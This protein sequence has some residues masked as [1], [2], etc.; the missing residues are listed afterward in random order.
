MPSDIFNWP[1]IISSNS[2]VPIFQPIINKLLAGADLLPYTLYLPS[3][4][5]GNHNSNPKLLYL[6]DNKIYCYEYFDNQI[7]EHIIATDRILYVEKGSILLMSWIKIV[8]FNQTDID[9]II[10]EFNTV[11]ENLFIPFIKS[12]R[13]MFTHNNNVPDITNNYI[14]QKLADL[15][16][17]YQTYL[18]QINNDNSS[19][20]S[21]VYQPIFK[22]K[23]LLFLKKLIT[24]PHMLVL[25]NNELIVVR[26]DKKSNKRKIKYGSTWTYIP[27]SKIDKVEISQDTS[28]YSNL[29]IIQQGN[30]TSNCIFQDDNG[31]A[32][33][34]FIRTLNT[35]LSS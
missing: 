27:I 6:Q 7:N 16:Y 8:F 12:V 13:S 35:I 21:F 30:C 33:T 1:Q 11:A 15:E 3:D 4:H 32:I 17:K 19:V 22:V 10:I 24:S 28:I 20:I 5:C 29:S 34:H 23:W 25:T 18:K 9:S 26:D 14:I 31:D 2:N